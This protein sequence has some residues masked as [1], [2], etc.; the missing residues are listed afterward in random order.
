MK[1]HRG[2][3]IGEVTGYYILV[4]ERA[5]QAA[6]ALFTVRNTN[7]ENARWLISPV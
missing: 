2:Q 7:K 5:W 1:Y 4:W 6:W 3:W